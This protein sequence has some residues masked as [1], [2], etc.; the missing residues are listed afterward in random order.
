MGY[1]YF[2]TKLDLI[3]VMV[4]LDVNIK[5]ACLKQIKTAI[6]N[7]INDIFFFFFFQFLTIFSIFYPL[8]SKSNMQI[9]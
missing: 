7:L 8:T 3:V 4:G 5:K 2:C 9:S 6:I 1:G